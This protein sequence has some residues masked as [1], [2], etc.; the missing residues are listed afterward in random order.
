MKRQIS[1]I[2]LLLCLIVSM[3]CL[4]GCS[5]KDVAP[6]TA[7]DLP[8]AV[9]GEKVADHNITFQEQEG[10]SFETKW[11]VWDDSEQF[12]IPY[13]DDTF[14]DNKVY[15]LTAVATAADGYI[16]N[17]ESF[18][19]L[20][21]ENCISYGY[22]I[23]GKLTTCTLE[24]GY[25]TTTTE[26]HRIEVMDSVFGVGKS[27]A[28]PK[29]VVYD[30]TDNELAG[31]VTTD[32][33]WEYQEIGSDEVLEINSTVFEE[34]LKYLLYTGIVANEGYSFDEDL[35]IVS[36]GID[37]MD[38]YDGSTPFVLNKYISYSTLSPIEKFTLTGL[39]KAKAGETMTSELTLAENYENCYIGV[40]WIDAEQ[41]DVT[42]T[43]FESGK[44]YEAQVNIC[45]YSF[46]QMVENPTVMIDGKTYSQNEMEVSET[47]IYIPIKYT[48]S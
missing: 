20:V 18:E 28:S 30:A 14:A 43:E 21:P 27:I 36:N 35:E 6:I 1:V 25:S 12:Y 2:L 26:I 5:K 23:D 44:T 22:T 16:F 34:N 31:A 17:E 32:I 15:M 11:L 3:L 48:I 39:P 46:Y 47:D 45:P 8:F 13:E 7:I 4:A 24:F 37:I 40:N 42:G 38:R 10:V 19:L 29:V 9:A 33:Q 41:N